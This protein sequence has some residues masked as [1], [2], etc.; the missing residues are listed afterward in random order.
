MHMLALPDSWLAAVLVLCILSCLYKIYIFIFSFSQ[1]GW[2][3]CYVLFKHLFTIYFS[4]F[5]PFISNF[6]SILRYI[7][8]PSEG[9][10]L[11][12]VIKFLFCHVADSVE[13]M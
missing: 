1:L 7:F 11:A 6:I 9:L 4:N 2:F 10:Y 13:H 3:I 12:G 5:L 8:Q